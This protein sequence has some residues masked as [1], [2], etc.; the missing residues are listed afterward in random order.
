MGYA[1][2]DFKKIGGQW[3]WVSPARHED[4]KLSTDDRDSLR[5]E[6]LLGEE[7][8]TMG[9]YYETDTLA[10][11]IDRSKIVP[12]YT[13]RFNK[14]LTASEWADNNGRAAYYR[15]AQGWKDIAQACKDNENIV[16]IVVEHAKQELQKTGRGRHSSILISI[17][18]SLTDILAHTRQHEKDIKP[19]LN[20]IMRALDKCPQYGTIKQDQHRLLQL[21]LGTT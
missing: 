17:G 14:A 19:L 1:L 15:I 18:E 4:L 10:E 7:N 2:N 8:D 12:G 9:L 3:A 20:I 6:R 21:A 13:G 11:L 5:M 16:P